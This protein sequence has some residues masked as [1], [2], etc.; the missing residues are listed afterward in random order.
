MTEPLSPFA[1]LCARTSAEPCNGSSWSAHARW[2]HAT[3]LPPSCRGSS[4]DATSFSVCH[5]AATGGELARSNAPQQPVLLPYPWPP[6]LHC[7]QDCAQGVWHGPGQVV[8]EGSPVD[9]FIRL[10]S[11]FYPVCHGEGCRFSVSDTRLLKCRREFLG[12]TGLIRY[13]HDRTL[14]PRVQLEKATHRGTAAA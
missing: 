1:D 2:D 12:L 13:S 10:W 7:Q 3:R 11:K 6:P 8:S 4:T 5:R 14:T 9:A